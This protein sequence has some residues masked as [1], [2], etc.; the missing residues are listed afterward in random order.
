[1]AHAARIERR[2]RLRKRIALH[3][4]E[5]EPERK[6]RLPPPVHHGPMRSAAE[7]RERMFEEMRMRNS[8]RWARSGAWA[9][10]EGL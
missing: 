8:K 5:P 9:D 4:P 1:M 7:R 3:V 10:R 6:P 2:D